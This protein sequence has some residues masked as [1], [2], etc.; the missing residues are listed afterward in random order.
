VRGDAANELF[1]LVAD[2]NVH[3]PESKVIT[4][5]LVPGRCRRRRTAAIAGGPIDR[6]DPGPR[7]MLLRDLVEVSRPDEPPEIEPDRQPEQA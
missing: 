5:D 7:A 1:P 4:A 3:I 6:R 2:P